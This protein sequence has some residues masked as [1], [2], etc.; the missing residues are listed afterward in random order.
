[1]Q[2]ATLS[3]KGRSYTS[4]SNAGVTPWPRNRSYL[5]VRG[6]LQPGMDA[7]LAIH[8]FDSNY[9]ISTCTHTIVAL[10]LSLLC[11]YNP[12][13]VLLAPWYVQVN[14]GLTLSC[15]AWIHNFHN[16]IHGLCRP[17]LCAK[18]IHTILKNARV[19]QV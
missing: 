8:C 10:P 11:I 19:T 15:K 18:Y 7:T 9:I 2:E 3:L 13:F 16:A 5:Q 12:C 14:H 4:V 6:S 1:M 17:M